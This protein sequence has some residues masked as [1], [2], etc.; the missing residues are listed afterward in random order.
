MR[1]E[2]TSTTD[3]AQNVQA[4]LGNTEAAK[5]PD[6]AGKS[7]ASPESATTSNSTS[8]DG[9][10]E[11]EP[12]AK[13]VV[14]AGADDQDTGETESGSDESGEDKLDAASKPKKQ[15]GGWQKRIDKKTRE[16]ADARREA[17][18]WKSQALKNAAAE[19]PTQETATKPA[20]DNAG[21]PDPAK[22]ETHAEYVE[23]VADWK[24][25]Q[26]LKAFQAEQEKARLLS[27]HQAKQKAYA[28][29]IQALAEKHEDFQ[30]ALESVADIQIP[31]HINAALLESDLGDELTYELAKNREELERIVKLSA[32]SA[33]REIGKIEA[34]IVSRTQKPTPSQETKKTTKAPKP[35]EPV[36]SKGASTDKSIYDAAQMTQKEYEAVRAKQRAE[37]QRSA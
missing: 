32:I 29:K 2:I 35:L 26:K 34:R 15:S 12:E 3:T 18:Y 33:A 25:D 23:A 27:E 22:F 37:A 36:G 24:A 30:E 31:A 5:A 11:S 19:K 14:Q 20:A 28:D 21:K 10:T 7:S 1:I 13:E 9:A 17:E 16:A 6:S 4:A 8:K